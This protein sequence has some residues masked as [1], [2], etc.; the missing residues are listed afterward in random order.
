MEQRIQVIGLRDLQ[1]ELKRLSDTG[2][3]TSEL[4]EA[5]KS[6]AEIVA[7]RARSLAPVRTGRLRDSI[8]AKASQRDASVAGGG[9]RVP[10]FGWIDF[11]GTI[12]L[13]HRRRVIKRPFIKEGRILYR[14]L[15][16][17]R[18]QVV[19][20]YEGA[21]SDLLKRAGLMDK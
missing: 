16:Q 19:R 18:E 10:Y 3:W 13:K 12:R 6:G 2:E 5:N 9:A 14:A 11:G 21:V 17:E 7:A 8:R 1:K 4:R 20:H 15:S